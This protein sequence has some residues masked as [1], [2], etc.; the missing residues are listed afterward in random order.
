MQSLLKNFF[1]LVQLPLNVSSAFP[2]R[3]LPVLESS[4]F[5]EV[6]S[7]FFFNFDPPPMLISGWGF[8]TVG[9]PC[10]NRK[11]PKDLVVART[12]FSGFLEWFLGQ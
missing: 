1:D 3:L 8:N 12:M 9:F 4:S 2:L 11:S 10:P 5:S 7:S 6:A